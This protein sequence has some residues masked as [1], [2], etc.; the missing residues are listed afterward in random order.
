MK[1]TIVKKS[2]NPN[3]KKEEKFCLNDR[4][5]EEVVKMKLI[6]RIYLNFSQNLSHNGLISNQNRE[7]LF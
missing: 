2:P 5:I 6:I 7:Y 1:T 3:D 4:V